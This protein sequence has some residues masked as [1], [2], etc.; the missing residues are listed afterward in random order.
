MTPLNELVEEIEA[1]R[2]YLRAER[3]MADNTVI[4]YGHDL[5]RFAEWFALGHMS[6][7][8]KPRLGELAEYLAFMR[9]ENLAPSSIARHL[10]SLKMLYRFLKLEERAD[11]SA[12]ELLAS[13]HRAMHTDPDLFFVTADFGSPVLDAIRADRPVRF[14]NVGIAEQNLINVSAGLALEGFTVFAYAIAPFITMRCFE[15][16]RVNL[17]LLS[18]VRA[19]NVNLIGVGALWWRLSSGPIMLDLATPWLASAIEQNL[20]GRY[21]V[22]F[23][24]TQLERDAQGR[25]ALRLRDIVVRDATGALV[26]TA[27]KAEVGLSGTSVLIARPRAES[28]RLVDANMVVRVESDGRAHVFVGGEHPLAIIEPAGTAPPVGRAR[29]GAS[30]A[31]ATAAPPPTAR[32]EPPRWSARRPGHSDCPSCTTSCLGRPARSVPV[33]G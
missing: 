13:L 11:P 4:S 18:E 32:R 33:L 12:V 6:D 1:F 19:L 3:G 30:P 20:G 7:F 23:G 21:R 10:V 14:I 28:F 25:T 29:P 2:S 22:Q 31:A 26:A 27:P 24:G 9:E 8:R 5:D 17:A 16:I 15:Q